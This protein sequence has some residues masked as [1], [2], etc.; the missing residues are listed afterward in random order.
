MHAPSS[1]PRRAL[2]A[3][4]L[5]GLGAA[6]SMQPDH[7]A[8]SSESSAPAPDGPTTSDAERVQIGGVH[9]YVDYEAA[10]EVAR[11]EEKALWVH[12]GENPG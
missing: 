3:A 2:S 12:F 10:L 1:F 6:C 7:E 4:L 5:L 9:W 8:P 11:Q